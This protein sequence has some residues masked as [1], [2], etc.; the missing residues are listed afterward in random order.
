MIRLAPCEIGHVRVHRGLPVGGVVTY[1]SIE[2]ID[3]GVGEGK[4]ARQ[5]RVEINGVKT[6]VHLPP[7]RHAQKAA[8]IERELLASYPE[9]QLL[10]INTVRPSNE[11]LI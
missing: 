9:L 4:I 8:V 10:V 1:L 11:S 7:E 6:S 2:A 5:V 3:E